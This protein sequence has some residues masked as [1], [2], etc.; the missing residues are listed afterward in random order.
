MPDHEVPSDVAAALA[1]A[2]EAAARWMRLPPSHRAEYLRWV[3][4]AKTPE[5]RARRVAQKVERLYHQ[6]GGGI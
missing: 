1:G 5:T 2:P 3:T 6:P 4:E